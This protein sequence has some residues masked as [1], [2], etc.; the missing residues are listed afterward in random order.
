[1]SFDPAHFLSTPGLAWQ[2]SLKNTK[3]E[4]DLLT[5][6]VMLLMIENGMKGAICHSIYQYAKANN[7]Q[8]KDYDK[9]KEPSYLQY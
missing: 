8:M 2:T 7:K 1:M 9:N 4:L 3:V 5:Y 6:I